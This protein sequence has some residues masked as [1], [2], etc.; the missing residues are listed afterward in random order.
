MKQ[1]QDCYKARLRRHRS[2]LRNVKECKIQAMPY[3]SGLLEETLLK[4]CF[5]DLHFS[6]L[7]IEDL[8][9]TEINF[10]T[11]PIFFNIYSR[12]ESQI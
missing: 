6:W 8:V 4:F 12:V 11:N 9:T 5:V 2:Q 10:T 1:P 7:P 3:V